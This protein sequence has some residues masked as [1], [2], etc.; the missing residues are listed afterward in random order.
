[1]RA[2]GSNQD[3]MDYRRDNM[4]AS[5][6]QTQDI[7]APRLATV[8]WQAAAAAS[9]AAAAACQAAALAWQAVLGKGRLRRPHIPS[10]T[11]CPDCR[12]CDFRGAGVF[13]E[14]GVGPNHRNSYI[15]LS[16]MTFPGDTRSLN[17][18]QENHWLRDL[19]TLEATRR[20]KSDSRL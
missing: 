11:P 6:T 9:Q 16:K 1:M 7:D 8:A 13:L 10:K 18:E 4:E 12:F 2:S 17:M 5:R 14:D 20:R 3:A 15:P 19:G